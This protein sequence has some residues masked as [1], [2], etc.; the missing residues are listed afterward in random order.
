MFAKIRFRRRRVRDMDCHPRKRFMDVDYCPQG[1]LVSIMKS[2]I[3]M[4]K[5]IC[6]R[7]LVD[8][9]TIFAFI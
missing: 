8:C 3:A 4:P 7:V 9:Y 1:A 5:M 6:D 2:E